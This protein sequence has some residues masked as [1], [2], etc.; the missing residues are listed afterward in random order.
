M[1][2]QDRNPPELW[3]VFLAARGRG[4]VVGGTV[5][6]VV[7]FGVF[8]QLD[9]GVVGLAHEST[10]ADR[11]GVG[12]RIDVRILDIDEALRRISLAPA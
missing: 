8:V 10:L 3:S 4:D 1:S 12:A 2:F 6:S 7:P 9:D 5:T 11:P